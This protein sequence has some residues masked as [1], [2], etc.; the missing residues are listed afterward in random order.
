MRIYTRLFISLAAAGI[1]LTVAN[2]SMAA[3]TASKDKTVDPVKQ[4]R[5]GCKVN[6]DNYSYESCM[7]KCGE[8]N[9]KS[10]PAGSTKK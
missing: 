6:K 8:K 7:I 1:L 3:G 4:C 5:E 9:K 2:F 10:N